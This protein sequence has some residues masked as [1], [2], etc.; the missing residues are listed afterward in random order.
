MRWFREG[1]RRR[2]FAL[3]EWDV[4]T[5]QENSMIISVNH[6]YIEGR[7]EQR[8][9]SSWWSSSLAK[10]GWCLVFCGWHCDFLKNLCLGK[11]V[12]WEGVLFCLFS[13]GLRVTFLSPEFCEVGDVHWHCVAQLWMPGQLPNGMAAHF[14]SSVVY[15]GSVVAFSLYARKKSLSLKCNDS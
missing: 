12:K 1:L 15:S 7:L 11:I 14:S 2:E 4:A 8:Q 5:K 9:K 10:I 6:S 13:R 3:N